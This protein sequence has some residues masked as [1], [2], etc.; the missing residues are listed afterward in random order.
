MNSN[1]CKIGAV[2]LTLVLLGT[3]F[4]VPASSVRVNNINTLMEKK[5]NP[6]DGDLE[7]EAFKLDRS[8]HE[9]PPIGPLNVDDNDDAGHK[10][11]AGDEIRRSIPIFPGEMEDN[12]PGRGRT[13]KLDDNGDDEDWFFFSVCD[14]QDI[15]C[16]MNPPTGFDFDLALWD[17]DEELL[18]SSTNTGNTP[19]S[20]I[21]TAVYTG[22]FFMQIKYISGTGEGQYSFDVEIQGQNDIGSGNDAGNSFATA[23]SISPG[24]YSGYLD[25]N[26][27]FDWYKFYA[28]QDDGIHFNLKMKSVAYLSDFDIYLYS[29]DEELV[30]YENY[31]Y[32]DDLLFPASM[33]GEW[34][35]KL[36]IFPGYSDIPQPTEWEYFTYGSGAYELL[37]EFV[38]DAP[39]PPGPITQPA[40]TPIA[41][42]FMLTNDHNSNKDEFGYMAAIPATN[43]LEGGKRYVAPIIYQGDTT[44]TNWFGTVDDTTDYLINDWNNYLAADEK[45]A[46]VYNIDSNPIVA[47]ADI[48]KT[49]WESSDLAVVA[50]DGSEYVDETNQVLSR[51]KTLTRKANVVTV[52]GDSEELVDMG[53]V[54]SYIMYLGQKI[55]SISVEVIGSAEEPYLDYLY[56][57]YMPVGDDWWPE[58][59]NEKTDIY[60][61]VS[62][63]GFWAPGVAQKSSDFD[64]KITTLE[65]DRYKISVDDH[66][67]AINVKVTTQSPSDLLVFLVDP[68]GWLRAPDMPDWNGG[69]INPIHVWNGMDNPSIPPGVDEWRAWEPEPHTEFSAE[70]LHP[71]KGDWT[72]IVVPRYPTG[73]SSIKYTITG[74]VREINPLRANAALSA[75]NAAVIASQEHAPLLYVTPNSVPTETEDAFNQLGVN[76]VI[77]VQ[78]ENIGSAVESQLPTVTDNLNTV[79]KTIDYIKDYSHSENYIPIT[80]LKSGKGTYAPTAYLAAYH[81]A[82]VLRIYYATDETTSVEYPLFVGMQGEN[83]YIYETATNEFTWTSQEGWH[84]TTSLSIPENSVYLG[85]ADDIIFAVD[86]TDWSPIWT[87]PIE[88]ENSEI[89]GEDVCFLPESNEI[90]LINKDGGGDM[91]PL[92]TPAAKNP[93]GMANRIDTWRLWAGDY[94]HGNRAPGH[95]PTYHEPLDIQDTSLIESV[96]S[97]LL[98]GEGELPPLGLDAKRYWNEALHNGIYEMIENFGLDGTGQEAYVFVADRKDIRLETH[99]VM[100]GLDS[101]AGHI[102][103]KTTSYINDIIVRN[104]LYP[105]LIYANPNRDVTTSQLMNFPD[106]GQWRTND[107]VQHQVCSSRVL[108]KM[109]SSHGR[110]FRG[111]CLWDA[112]LEE[113]NNGA[114]V[115]YYSGHGTGGSGMS[116]QYI[117]TDNCNYPEQIWYDAWRG[118]KFDNWKT[119]RN[120]GMVWYNPEPANLYDIIHYKWIDQLFDNLRSCAVFYMSCS[121]GQQFGPLVYLDHGAVMWYGNAGSGLCPEADLMDDWFFED[122]LYHGLNVGEA[123]SQYVWLHFRDFTT[124]DPTAMYGP[125]SLY[126]GEGITTVHSIYGD[127]NLILYSP[128]W[129]I[130]NPVDSNIGRAK[131]K[132]V[133]N[134]PRTFRDIIIDFI[135]DFLKDHPILSK[136]LLS[137]PFIAKLLQN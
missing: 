98:T 64:L 100:L 124:S 26:D 70:V 51:T 16:T 69:P 137:Q 80:S 84:P 132:D 81:C 66:D 50:I 79:Q 117:Q 123:Y 52:P 113:M 45:E 83:M 134:T 94:Y 133:P 73:S 34:R 1:N 118:Y 31:Y 3:A 5:E 19:E 121:T 99:S 18:A 93:A 111:H 110:T 17:E 55:G 6:S 2:V 107:G 11:D 48:A 127:P 14:G 87:W 71:E 76:E 122:T 108:K 4:F 95:L 20:F 49:C 125:S 63:Q 8:Y 7:V 53:A 102:P 74:T 40:I 103:G 96:L 35:V 131:T 126:G 105:A 46:E 36:C 130:P 54:Y 91:F 59:V 58:H 86:P 112:H 72:A 65:C 109:F 42:T 10:D 97:F 92:S 119:P 33:S 136:I 135:N 106:C 13:G 12:F 44:P 25:M 24:E 90:V 23:T 22:R 43:Y 128:D 104:V 62:S 29:P 129:E 115:F 67:S 28:D 120:N 85:G 77:F 56:P 38:S 61:P 41:Q 114:S 30:H 75:A 47:A 37:F 9:D 82:P 116:A 89:T 32:D 27:E 68:K 21:T 88:Y 101:Y 60:H 15:A 57:G 78:L 39:S